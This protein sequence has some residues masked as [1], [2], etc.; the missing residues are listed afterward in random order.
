M[1]LPPASREP[2]SAADDRIGWISACGAQ[3]GA[4]L[5]VYLRRTTE[6]ADVCG[7]LTADGQVRAV[8]HKCAPHVLKMPRS[9]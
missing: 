1:L 5:I 8:A 9:Y 2:A 4:Q 7:G 3:C 6:R